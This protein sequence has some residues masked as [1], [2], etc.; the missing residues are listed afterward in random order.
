LEYTNINVPDGTVVETLEEARDGLGNGRLEVLDELVSVLVEELVDSLGKLISLAVEQILHFDV[1]T[2]NI[3]SDVRIFVN[4]NPV[5]PDVK[6][7]LASD[8]GV[9]EL[10]DI[11]RGVISF[12]LKNSNFALDDVLANRLGVWDEHG[13]LDGSGFF[14]CIDI[15]QFVLSKSCNRAD[16]SSEILRHSLYL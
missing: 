10:S 3:N 14:V 2:A 15:N 13:H 16:R 11:G 12:Q 4:N 7:G 6:L 9:G 5:V 8:G 1:E